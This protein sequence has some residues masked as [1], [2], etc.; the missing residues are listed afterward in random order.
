M[1]N[2]LLKSLKMHRDNL[3]NLLKE[4]APSNKFLAELMELREIVLKLNLKTSY[5]LNEALNCAL[6]DYQYPLKYMRNLMI[7]YVFGLI[8]EIDEALLGKRVKLGV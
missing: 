6:K 7:S 4:D 8:K 3:V 2:D 1:Q 5:R